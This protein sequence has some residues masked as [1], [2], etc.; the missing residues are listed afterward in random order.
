[1]PP[2]L[3]KIP[4]P[5][6]G[7]ARRGKPTA[8]AP[9]GKRNLF[10]SENAGK[11]GGGR[12]KGSVSGVQLER[13]IRMDG[14]AAELLRQMTAEERNAMTSVDVLRFAMKAYVAIGDVDKAAKA[15]AELAP[16]EAPRL[17]AQA[18][19]SE[20]GLRALGKQDIQRLLA[21]TRSIA[22]AVDDDVGEGAGSAGSGEQ[23]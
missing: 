17:A 10:T 13:M 7:Q 18:F 23:D 21:F 3:T 22:G 5:T 4:L 19:V 11:Q 1:M 9:T 15:A 12:K 16:Y 6:A 14:A 2:D 20:D 8:G